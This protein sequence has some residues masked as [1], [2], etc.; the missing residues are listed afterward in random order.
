MNMKYN[1]IFFLIYIYIYTYTH[2]YIHGGGAHDRRSGTGQPPQDSAQHQP[3]EPLQ[4]GLYRFFD[5]SAREPV[6][7]ADGLDVYSTLT[8]RPADVRAVC[9]CVCALCVCVC[10]V[11]VCHVWVCHVWVCH[12]CVCVPCVCAGMCHVCVCHEFVCL[13]A[14]AREVHCIAA[15]TCCCLMSNVLCPAAMPRLMS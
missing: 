7:G 12:V 5:D 14:W 11:C 6:G 15:C 9:V 2:T 1:Y 10:H 3:H 8:A 13:A 4:L